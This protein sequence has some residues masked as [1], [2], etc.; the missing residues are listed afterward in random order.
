MWFES[1]AV[2]C[3]HR[4]WGLAQGACLLVYERQRAGQVVTLGS[5]LMAL[6]QRWSARQ[7]YDFYRARRIVA[8]KRHKHPGWEIDWFSEGPYE[9]AQ[10]TAEERPSD[11]RLGLLR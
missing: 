1:V 7:I 5:L 11:L 9:Q 6:G 3:G 10:R 2:P 8:T 4:H